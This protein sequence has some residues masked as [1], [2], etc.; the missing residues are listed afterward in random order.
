VIRKEDTLI[1]QHANCRM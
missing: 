1:N